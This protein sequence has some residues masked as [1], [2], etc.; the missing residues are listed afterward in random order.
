VDAPPTLIS[1][2]TGVLIEPARRTGH[3]TMVTQAMVPRGDGRRQRPRDWSVV[4]RQDIRQRRARPRPRCGAGSQRVRIGSHLSTPAYSLS[5]R[6]GQRERRGGKYLTDTTGASATGFVP[7]LA[8]HL[9]HNG[10]RRRRAHLHAWWVDNNRLDFPRGY[11]IEPSGGL[12]LP[13]F[14]VMSGHRA[15][16]APAAATGS[17][18][19]RLSALLWD[20]GQL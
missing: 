4:C 13:G 12:R 20:Q 5:T 16:L 7:R 10:R 14:G 6:S 19:E 17:T 11:H 1:R 2:V 8:D 9:P 18:Q 15:L 3:L